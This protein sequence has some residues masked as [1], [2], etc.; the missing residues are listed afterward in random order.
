MR[1][2]LCLFTGRFIPYCYIRF[3]QHMP[4]L[5]LIYSSAPVPSG[6]HVS[7]GLENHSRSRSHQDDP[8]HPPRSGIRDIGKFATSKDNLYG[9]VLPTVTPELRTPRSICLMRSAIHIHAWLRPG[10]CCC[11]CCPPHF[12]LAPGRF[13][14]LGGEGSRFGADRAHAPSPALHTHLRSSERL[15]HRVSQSVPPVSAP[16]RLSGAKV[17]RGSVWA[18]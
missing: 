3:T 9:S 14:R 6:G 1:L 5:T 12:P 11:C 8:T 13:G 18:P 10:Q 17:P 2:R 7:P 4:L 16:C 15:E